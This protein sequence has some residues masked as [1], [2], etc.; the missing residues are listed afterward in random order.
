MARCV[1]HGRQM[2]AEA[3]G[4]IL[5][6]A[7][8]DPNIPGSV[9]VNYLMLTGTVLGGW[10]MARAAVAAQKYLDTGDA[11]SGFYQSRIAVSRFYIEQVMPRAKAYLD[12][13]LAGADNI[14]ELP[15]DLL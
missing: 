8:A 10:Q 4:W 13:V 15:A 9:S 6:H 1:A 12:A 14:M 7:E 3:T 5:E 11:N 2:L